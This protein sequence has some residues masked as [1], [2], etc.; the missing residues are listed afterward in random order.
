MTPNNAVPGAMFL[1]WDNGHVAASRPSVGKKVRIVKN[2]D[3]AEGDRN[4]E[5][6]ED[7]LELRAAQ[8][9]WRRRG[10]KD[11]RIDRRRGS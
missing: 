3:A 2:G 9:T 6:C 10:E 1:A 8:C 7:G 4:W 5:R 11:R